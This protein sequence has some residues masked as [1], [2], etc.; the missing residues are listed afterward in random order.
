MSD[1]FLSYVRKDL[2]IAMQVAEHLREQGLT[3]FW[4][5]EIPVGA[6]WEGYI[7]EQLLK[8]KSVVVI[9]FSGF[10]LGSCGSYSGC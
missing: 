9:S 10:R 8:A 6:T 5:R 7:E 2:A 1:V 4:D 3:V